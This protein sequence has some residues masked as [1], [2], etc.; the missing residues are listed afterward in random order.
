[1]NIF[2]CRNGVLPGGLECIFR[3]TR[4]DETGNKKTFGCL[5]HGGH[6]GFDH[7]NLYPEHDPA[8]GDAV[9]Q[10]TNPS[11]PF[12]TGEIILSWENLTSHQSG[13]NYD[14]RDFPADIHPQ[15]S[16]A[17]HNHPTKSFLGEDDL[18]EIFGDDNPA[19]VHSGWNTEKFYKIPSVEYCQGGI[20]GHYD[21]KSDMIMHSCMRSHLG[22]PGWINYTNRKESAQKKDLYIGYATDE[23]IISFAGSMF[24]D[25]K[26]ALR[27]ADAM[28][29]VKRG[30]FINLWTLMSNNFVSPK[31][32]REF[33]NRTSTTSESSIY[34]GKANLLHFCALYGHID[35]MQ[36]YEQVTDANGVTSMV[37]KATHKD[38]RIVLKENILNWVLNYPPLKKILVGGSKYP[39]DQRYWFVVLLLKQA[40]KDGI[41]NKKAMLPDWLINLIKAKNDPEVRLFGEIMNYSQL[42]AEY[43][44]EYHVAQHA[45][46]GTTPLDTISSLYPGMINIKKELLGDGKKIDILGWGQFLEI[47]KL[48]RRWS[49]SE[50]RNAFEHFIPSWLRDEPDIFYAWLQAVAD[51]PMEETDSVSTDEFKELLKKEGRKAF[52]EP[53][54]VQILEHGAVNFNHGEGGLSAGRAFASNILDASLDWENWV[55][56]A[57]WNVVRM[58]IGNW[59]EANA[60]VRIVRES[61]HETFWA[62]LAAHGG[63][64]DDRKE[65][66]RILADQTLN[67][68]LSQDAYEEALESSQHNIATTRSTVEAGLDGEDLTNLMCDDPFN[69]TVTHLDKGEGIWDGEE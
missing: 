31:V 21:P 46:L 29:E 30:K 15:Y 58:P 64:I 12:K 45:Y 11:D 62:M 48:G 36:W 37:P 50:I 27:M 42:P 47:L 19:L 40:K 3:I 69:G 56:W 39:T 1:M 5:R 65:I 52:A 53:G 22:T 33:M 32:K 35:G 59:F 25:K 63:L 14:F 18:G 8:T 7:Y 13:R 9:Y 43:K 16:I 26:I 68:T 10:P 28:L 20:Y 34:R 66:D 17:E 67:E 6:Q 23:E 51:L 4:M 57:D 44:N 54:P 49:I 41:L 2:Q 61:G 55:T 38:I 60:K 24:K